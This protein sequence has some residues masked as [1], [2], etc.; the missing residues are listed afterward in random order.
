[1]CSERREAIAGVAL[2]PQRDAVD[3]ELGGAAGELDLRVD[4]V[5][6]HFVALGAA[7]LPPGRRPF[8]IGFSSQSG[9][10]LRAARPVIGLV[11]CA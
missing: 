6:A 7:G 2:P 3:I 8:Q 10:S 1:M 4:D 9:C 11:Y 5:L